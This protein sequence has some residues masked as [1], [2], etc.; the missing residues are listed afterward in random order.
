M[1]SDYGPERTRSSVR[2]KMFQLL[3]S[4]FRTWETWT[5]FLDLLPRIQSG[6]SG[7]LA[8]LNFD[9]LMGNWGS[10]NWFGFD[11]EDSVINNRKSLVTSMRMVQ[12]QSVNS[13]YP[14][15]FSYPLT[16][17]ESA[18]CLPDRSQMIPALNSSVMSAHF[19]WREHSGGRS[20]GVGTWTA[21][22]KICSLL[23]Y[24]IVA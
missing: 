17:P 20:T 14:L 12:V 1:T 13:S 3:N 5:N 23:R 18:H 24:L 9:F 7:H 21:N 2:D 10:E 4:Y 11:T 15:A 19:I 6:T 22:T 8:F 16:P